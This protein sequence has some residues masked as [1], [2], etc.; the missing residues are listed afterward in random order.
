MTEGTPH[1][2]DP[3]NEALATT[4]LF[5]LMSA[6]IALAVA[7]ASWGMSELVIAALAGSAAVISFTASIFCFK[8]EATDRA[9]AE[10]PM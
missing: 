6:V 10:A 8:T 2:D 9:V 7:L 5:L 4:G 3:F 1:A